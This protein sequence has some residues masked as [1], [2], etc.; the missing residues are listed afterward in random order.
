[1]SAT[2]GKVNVEGVTR[3][4]GEKVFVLKFLQSRNPDWV[5]RPFFAKYDADASWISDLKP[6]FG[7]DRFFFADEMDV[8]R[9]NP[10]M[11]PWQ[12]ATS[13]A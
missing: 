8:L 10:G 12:V 6:A 4:G 1:M 13:A 7:E 11:K 9:E 2:P 3:V 5:K